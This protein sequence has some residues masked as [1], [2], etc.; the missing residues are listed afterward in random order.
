LVG[1]FIGF[2]TGL[3]TIEAWMEEQWKPKIKG[4]NFVCMWLRVFY[5]LFIFGTRGS[6][7]DISINPLIHGISWHV[8]V[9][10]VTRFQPRRRDIFIPYLVKVAPLSSHI[11]GWR[12]L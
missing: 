6:K 4:C 10:L 8:L 11:W 3:K 9:T 7:F 1:N 12:N 2:R 5:F